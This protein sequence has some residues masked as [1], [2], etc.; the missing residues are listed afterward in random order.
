MVNYLPSYSFRNSNRRKINMTNNA[1]NN[2]NF[3]QAA[4][5]SS[6]EKKKNNVYLNLKITTNS[7]DVR[8]FSFLLCNSGSGIE[9]SNANAVINTAKDMSLEEANAY[10]TSIFANPEKWKNKRIEGSCYLSGIKASSKD[11]VNDF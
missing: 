8:R 9:Q 2:M 11:W 1:L 6:E 4:A 10:L 5:T 7:G 3:N